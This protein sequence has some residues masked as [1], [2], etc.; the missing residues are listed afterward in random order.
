MSEMRVYDDT[1]GTAR[2]RSC[3]AAITWFELTS[4]KSHPFDGEPVY[5]RTEHDDDRRIVGVIDTSVS[6]SHFAT[7]PDAKDWRRR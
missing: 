1:R 2:C 7:C 5:V 3:D 6:S 4:G